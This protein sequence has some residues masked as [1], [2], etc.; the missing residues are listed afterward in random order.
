MAVC[1]VFEFPNEPVEKYEK[2]FESGGPAITDQP[3]RL[4][5]VCYRTTEGFTVIDVWADEASFAAFGE[6]IGPATAQAG[7]D[8]KPMVYPVQGLISQD[9]RRSR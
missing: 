5:H 4:S 9:G 2:V 8:A 7:L 6:V 3:A 1:A